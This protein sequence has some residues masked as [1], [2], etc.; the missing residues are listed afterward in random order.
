[1][2]RYLSQ[3]QIYHDPNLG[4]TKVESSLIAIF[5]V[6]SYFAS[7][8][9]NPL[10]VLFF[11]FVCVIFFKD[12]QTKNTQ[13]YLESWKCLGIFGCNKLLSSS[14][15]NMAQNKRLALKEISEMIRNK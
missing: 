5:H 1:M 3:H 14:A 11:V 13:L 12:Q 8:R 9:T 4:D 6:L 2:P 10:W 15:S 7:I